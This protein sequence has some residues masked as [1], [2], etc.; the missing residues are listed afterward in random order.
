VR[1]LRVVVTSCLIGG[2]GALAATP[3]AAAPKPITGKLG[4]RGYTVIAL[5]ANGK[6]TSVRAGRG[7][8]ELRPPTT[9]ATLHLRGADGV[10]AGPLVA[11]RDGKRAIVGV[12]A[13]ARLG[14]IEVVA[15]GGYA[16]VVKRQS[17]SE[18]DASRT[19][20]AKNGVPIGAGVFGRV[21]A[22]A[23]RGAVPGDLDIDGIPDRVDIDDDGDKVL[24]KVD[25]TPRA[26]KAQAPGHQDP[27]DLAAALASPLENTANVNAGSTDSQIAGVLPELGYLLM[28]APE[29]YSAELDCGGTRNPSPPPPLV[30]GLSYCSYGGTG[31]V[32]FP[33]PRDV[34]PECCDADRDG[35]GTLEPIER[36]PDFTNFKLGHHATAAQIGTGDTLI[37]RLTRDGHETQLTDTQQF[38]FATTPALASYVDEAGTRTV[39]SYPVQAGDPGTSGNGFPVSDGP[40]ADS[41]VEVSVTLW[42][43]QRRPTSEQEC[44][45]PGPGCMER[46]WIDVGGLDYTAS[47]REGHERTRDAGWCSQAD[48]ASSDSSLSPGFP[49]EQ[50]GGFRDLAPSRPANVANTFTYTLNLTRCLKAFGVGFASGETQAFGFEAFTPIQGGGSAGVDNASTVVFFTR[51]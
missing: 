18:L 30:G 5:A 50:G 16:R 6:V 8:F 23:K 19:A 25:R 44:S 42:R 15:D 21:R 40:D 2:C 4:Q 45:Q 11:G 28:S 41:D 13:G 20:R 34:F 7:T 14:E 47:S 33:P 9:S 12:R 37:L 38:I 22:K 3:A 43:P 27:F 1:S 51:R 36:G 29:G 17:K 48:F 49:D 10:Y 35:Y 24:D 32:G 26:R 39:V 31:R 46:E